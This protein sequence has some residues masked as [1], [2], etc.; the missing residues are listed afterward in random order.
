MAVLVDTNI[1]AAILKGNSQAANAVSTLQPVINTV[2]WVEL[3]QGSKS[4][5]VVGQL[6]QYLSKIPIIH[7]DLQ[8]SFE[9]MRLIE[10]YSG[11]NG[12]LLGDAIIAAT[13]LVY[14]IPLLTLNVKHFNFVPGLVLAAM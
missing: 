9:T 1:F 14:G 11:S 12:L 5:L 7:F 3:I 4:K 8:I 2:V 10:A 6:R 13:C